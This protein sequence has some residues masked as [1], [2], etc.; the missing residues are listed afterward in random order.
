[1]VMPKYRAV[2]FVHGCFWHRH[3][4]CRYATVPARC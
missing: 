4:G 2:I 1:M 3:T